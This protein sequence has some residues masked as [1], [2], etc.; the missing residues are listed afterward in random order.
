MKVAPPARIPANKVAARVCG[1]NA[2]ALSG[3]TAR[4]FSR[5]FFK[6]KSAINRARLSVLS[7]ALCGVFSAY[8]Q[9]ASSGMLGE[10][11]VTANGF[12]ESAES[13]PY[14]VSVLTA[15]DIAQSGAASV[16][17]AIMK[18]LGIPGRLDT[19][20]GNNYALDLRGFGQ[21]AG[22]NQVVIVDGKRLNE[23]DLS[24]SNPGVVSIDSVQRIEVIRGNAAVVY[25]EG[26]TGG[27]IVISTKAGLGVARQNTAS[28]AAA[29]GSNGLQEVRTSATV[30]SAGLSLDVFGNDRKSDGHRD[31]FASENNNLGATVQWSNDWLRLGAQAAR[32]LQHSGFPGSLTAAEYAENPRRAGSS[33]NYG[34]L[35]SEVY[36]LF[37]E[38]MVADWQIGL[39]HGERTKKTLGYYG[40]SY[41]PQATVNASNTNLRARMDSEGRVFSNAFTLGVD[42]NDWKY[43]NNDPSNGKSES[44]AVYV[45]NDMNYLPSGTRVSV[46]LRN[47]SVKK[48]RDAVS[49]RI[50]DAQTAWH[51]G[52][53]QELGYGMR[54]FGRTGQSFRFA[55]VDE[56][57]Y[58]TPGTTLKVQTSRDAE[59][60]VR[61]LR[62]GSH[63]ELR[64][65]RSELNNEI[66]YDNTAV[67][68]GSGFGFPGANVNFGQTLRQGLELEARHALSTDLSVRVGAAARQA[69]FVDGPY[70]GK[71][72][73]LVPAHTASLGLD[74]NVA[75]GH[76][77][78]LG[79]NWVSSQS[80]DFAN[81]CTMPAYNTVDARYAY[82]TGPAELSLGINNVGDTK[83]YTQAY[84]CT[85]AGV[86]T[87]IYPEAGRSF[88][89]T[90]KLKF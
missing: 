44:N 3:K 13:L 36:G 85:A 87:A 57:N 90:A 88:T 41:I 20:G 70:A 53:T 32:S 47:E 39:D 27:A 29:T 5:V 46:G 23:Q 51:L 11:V 6:M 37:A 8:G 77:V 55:N 84:G 30:V 72:I 38:A 52:L 17:E 60:G 89:V 64:W 78:N 75:A 63:A 48:S 26:A 28:I 71:D 31:N 10:V 49:T 21:T 74:W 25:G 16:S 61:W 1:L 66:G 56:I 24:G 35:K 67:G 65:Y 9:T 4:V 18:L 73:A 2:Q 40:P 86:T 80:P 59:L 7:V 62:A 82:T 15:K 58:V 81:K 54:V 68:P 69:R 83:Y 45:T 50:D 22:G 76:V 19:S 12:S 34:D 33:V 79:A 42:V 14:G 43:A